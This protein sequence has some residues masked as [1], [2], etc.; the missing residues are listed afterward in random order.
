LYHNTSRK[1]GLN[2]S[3]IAFLFPSRDVELFVGLSEF[4]CELVYV[5]DIKVWNIGGPPPTR[6]PAR[7]SA[8]GQT[9]LPIRTAA[10]AEI[11]YRS[12]ATGH[13]TTGH[14]QLTATTTPSFLR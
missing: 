8:A 9:Y 2:S 1:N 14:A 12:F 11:L 5:V 6:Y 3:L 7:P 10:R 13:P 4:V